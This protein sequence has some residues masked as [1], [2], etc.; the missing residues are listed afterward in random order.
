MLRPVSRDFICDKPVLNFEEQTGGR[1]VSQD[2]P[3][4]PS[5][6]LLRLKLVSTDKSSLRGDA[7]LPPRIVTNGFLQHHR[8]VS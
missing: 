5:H 1:A 8:T 7:H 6:S 4:S 2:L 3:A